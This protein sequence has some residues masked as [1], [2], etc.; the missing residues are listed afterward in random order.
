M[1][2]LFQCSMSPSQSSCAASQSSRHAA[3]FYVDPYTLPKNGDVSHIRGNVPA[4]LKQLNLNTFQAYGV[5]PTDCFAH[6]VG[7]AI[8][9]VEIDTAERRD[10]G[11]G[12]LE[13][14]TVA[15]VTVAKGA[16][17]PTKTCRN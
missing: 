11:S 1:H 8:T 12:S 16:S 10:G 17:A 14:R 15:E 7:K 13:V 9:F 2:L 6:T 4:L 3:Q 5:G